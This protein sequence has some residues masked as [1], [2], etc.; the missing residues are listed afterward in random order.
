MVY[1]KHTQKKRH[2]AKSIGVFFDYLF[3][4]ENSFFPAFNRTGVFISILYSI[5]IFVTYK[6]KLLVFFFF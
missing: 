5:H 2:K 4:Q 6:K 1:T 3:E